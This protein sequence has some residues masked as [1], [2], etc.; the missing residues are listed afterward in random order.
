MYFEGIF[1][2]IFSDCT[3]FFG[4]KVFIAKAIINSTSI[5]VIKNSVV[6]PLLFYCPRG[7][8]KIKIRSRRGI[9]FSF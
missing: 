5:C 9:Q 4:I 6:Q 2:I 3:F 8:F 1:V 7:T